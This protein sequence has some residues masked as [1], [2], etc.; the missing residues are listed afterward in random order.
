MDG[1]TH[2]ATGFVFGLTTGFVHYFNGLFPGTVDVFINTNSTALILSG[3][4]ACVIGVLLPDIDIKGSKIGKKAKIVN[5]IVSKLFSHRGIIHTPIVACFLSQLLYLILNPNIPEYA[6]YI[7]IMFFCGYL[8]HL[9]QDIFTTK[10][11]GIMYLYPY[12]KRFYIKPLQG[13]IGKKITNVF[14]NLIILG[15]FIFVYIRIFL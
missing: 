4:T 5:F 13:K 3:I 6:T 11:K 2:A 7:T 12:S 14:G 1:R 15:L 8:L 9:F 10:N